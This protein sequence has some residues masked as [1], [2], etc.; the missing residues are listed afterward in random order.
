MRHPRSSQEGS[1]LGIG[2]K[3]SQLRHLFL[4]WRCQA[5]ALIERLQESAQT[6]SPR[7][8]ACVDWCG[9]LPGA[10]TP[11][12]IILNFPFP[13]TLGWVPPHYSKPREQS[14]ARR[15]CRTY[16]VSPEA[17]FRVPFQVRVIPSKRMISW[18]PTLE[19]ILPVRRAVNSQKLCLPDT[20]HSSTR[21]LNFL[22]YAV[23]TYTANCPA[24]NKSK[25]AGPKPCP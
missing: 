21:P 12:W 14:K 10:A 4:N 3:L 5:D 15:S 9:Q 8:R 1:I 11:P 20:P 19:S 18:P 2:S 16:C 24:S 22:W 6:I 23:T 25:R 13:N 17:T 7:K